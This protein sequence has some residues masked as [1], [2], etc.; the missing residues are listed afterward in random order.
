MDRG[1]VFNL[2]NHYMENCTPADAKVSEYII[3]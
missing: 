3:V 1:F 2:I